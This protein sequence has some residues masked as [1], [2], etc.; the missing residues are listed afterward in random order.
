MNTQIGDYIHIIHMSGEPKYDDKIGRVQSID[1]ANQ[2]HGTWGGCALTEEDDEF[3]IISE[4]RFKLY[5]A[6][7]KYNT[8]KKAMAFLVEYYMKSLKWSE[9]Q[10]CKYAI[11]LFKNGTITSI[12]LLNSDGDEI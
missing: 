8:K 9:K 5:K 4:D 7:E 1:N 3:E 10:S 11:E 2:I 6:C 12:K